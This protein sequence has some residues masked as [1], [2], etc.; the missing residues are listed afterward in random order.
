MSADII[1]IKPV[2]GRR[3]CGSLYVGGKRS[4]GRGYCSASAGISPTTAATQSSRAFEENKMHPSNV[5]ICESTQEQTVS[6][7]QLF[8]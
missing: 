8:L 6:A 5:N 2:K 3:P 1:N 4:D 7:G